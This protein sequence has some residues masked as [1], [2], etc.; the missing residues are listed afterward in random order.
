MI[1]PKVFKT[2]KDEL[3]VLQSTI[4]MTHNSGVHN[5]TK[6]TTVFIPIDGVRDDDIN[7]TI[8]TYHNGE[9]FFDGKCSNIHILV[10]GR[11]D[12]FDAAGNRYASFVEIDIYRDGMFIL[13]FGDESKIDFSMFSDDYE[14]SEKELFEFFLVTDT[15]GL[16]DDLV[17]TIIEVTR[18]LQD[19]DM[20]TSTF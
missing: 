11:N 7:L 18:V 16:P 17:L 5:S 4:P 19:T 14:I 8:N 12:D 13:G 3:T 20:F 10:V 15:M 6:K 1:N 9:T 2:I